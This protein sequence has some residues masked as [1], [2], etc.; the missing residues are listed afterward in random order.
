MGKMVKNLMIVQK[1]S[2]AMLLNWDTKLVVV[3]E[4]KRQSELTAKT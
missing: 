3:G 2:K 4:V 1:I